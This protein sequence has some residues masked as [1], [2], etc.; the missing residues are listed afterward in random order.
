MSRLHSHQHLVMEIEEVHG[1]YSLRDRDIQWSAKKKHTHWEKDE[2]TVWNQLVRTPNSVSKKKSSGK[3]TAGNSSYQCNLGY[4][5]DKKNLNS[6]MKSDREIDGDYDLRSR[7]LYWHIAGVPS[8][9]TPSIDRL[10]DCGYYHDFPAQS[11]SSASASASFPVSGK[12]KQHLSLDSVDQDDI[13]DRASLKKKP[14]AVASSRSVNIMTGTGSL[15]SLSGEIEIETET[16][17]DSDNARRPLGSTSMKGSNKVVKQDSSTTTIV[18]PQKSR[19]RRK[20]LC[21]LDGYDI[22]DDEGVRSNKSSRCYTSMSNN[23][24]TLS[25]IKQSTHITPNRN[26]SVNV[27]KSPMV[28]G[29][30]VQSPVTIT[31]NLSDHS[32]NRASAAYPSPLKAINASTDFKRIS[33]LQHKSNI[34]RDLRDH[35]EEKRKNELGTTIDSPHPSSLTSSYTMNI[36]NYDGTRRLFHLHWIVLFSLFVL[37]IAVSAYVQSPYLSLVNWKGGYIYVNST[38]KCRR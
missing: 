36:E 23:S 35:N 25:Y 21:G 9:C 37:F 8:G 11:A 33:S 6:A 32:L 20:S 38:E 2:E 18:T 34:S 1:E 28:S 5:H 17:N 12:R 16:D 15:S 26:F 29:A 10:C 19:V 7:H 3:G 14:R 22:A 24:R 4:F 27:T 31:T 13:T 30:A